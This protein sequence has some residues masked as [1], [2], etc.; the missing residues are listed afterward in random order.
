MKLKINVSPVEVAMAPSHCSE[1]GNIK[2]SNVSLAFSV[3]TV[4]QDNTEL[5]NESSSS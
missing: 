3:Q 4:L 1:K 2:E 5:M